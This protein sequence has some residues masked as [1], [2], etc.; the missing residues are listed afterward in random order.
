MGRVADVFVGLFV[1]VVRRS[2]GRIVGELAA[3]PPGGACGLDDLKRWPRLRRAL[4]ET[5]RLYPPL[6][7]LPVLFT[8]RSLMAR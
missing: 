3:F 4:L 6:S 1:A 8:S 2:L 5:L 7:V